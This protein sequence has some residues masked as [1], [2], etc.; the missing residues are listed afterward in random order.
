MVKVFFPD[1][2]I[3]KQKGVIM[4]E[5]EIKRF[6]VGFSYEES[7]SCM[8]DAQNKQEAIA[9]MTE[10]LAQDGVDGLNYETLGRDYGAHSADEITDYPISSD[11]RYGEVELEKEHF[12]SKYEVEVFLFDME[13]D[14]STPYHQEIIEVEADREG[15]ALVMA[16]QKAYML[17]EAAGVN[18]SIEVEII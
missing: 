7:G 10:R 2:N 8:V 5:Q 14:P 4:A 9:I 1:L 15:N 6:K 11:I 16:R 3:H 18:I 13:E 12:E 17:P